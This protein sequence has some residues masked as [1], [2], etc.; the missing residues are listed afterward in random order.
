MIISCDHT[1]PFTLVHGQQA[2]HTSTL[3]STVDSAYGTLPNSRANSTISTKDNLD[4]TCTKQ[5]LH[6]TSYPP[7]SVS[8]PPQQVLIHH[9]KE[10]QSMPLCDV[11]AQYTASKYLNKETI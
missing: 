4:S 6:R 10:L 5:Q 2:L 9:E 8:L 7:E 3:Q 11:S 1:D